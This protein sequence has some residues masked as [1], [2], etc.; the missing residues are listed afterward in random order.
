MAQM[1][2][3]LSMARQERGKRC[4][5]ATSVLNTRKLSSRR[6]SAAKRR[7][8]DLGLTPEEYLQKLIKD[9]LAISAKAKTT[10]FHEL[11]APFREALAGVGE[12]ELD[13]RVKAA[14]A[15]RRKRNSIR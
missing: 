3:R 13:R 7:A 14:R 15:A 2:L 12:T 5:M 9:D 10:S 8:H 11:A 6:V 4:G 1:P